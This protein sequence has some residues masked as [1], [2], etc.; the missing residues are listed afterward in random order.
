MIAVVSPDA[1]GDGKSSEGGFN[2]DDWEHPA[3][4]DD[5]EPE[6]LS[7]PF[8]CPWRVIPRGLSGAE[9]PLSLVRLARECSDEIPTYSEVGDMIGRAKKAAE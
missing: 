2:L 8:F 3:E 5:W 6:R 7:G 4:G 1:A 9:V